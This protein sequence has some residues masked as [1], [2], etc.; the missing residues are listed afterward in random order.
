MLLHLAEGEDVVCTIKNDDIPPGLT[1]EMTLIN[2][3]D[4]NALAEEFDLSATGPSSF[5]NTGPLVSSQDEVVDFLAGTYVLNATGVDSY[6]Y[7]SLD[8]RWR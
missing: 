7:G 6:D 8:L 3:V 4:G 5:S 1:L 2:G